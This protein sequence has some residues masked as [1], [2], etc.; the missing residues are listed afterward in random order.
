MDVIPVFKQF[1]TC[2]SPYIPSNINIHIIDKKISWI[3]LKHEMDGQANP[4]K[5]T[6]KLNKN[7]K[8]TS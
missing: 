3:S 4:N 6:K 2:T 8:W 1:S 5:C 7:R